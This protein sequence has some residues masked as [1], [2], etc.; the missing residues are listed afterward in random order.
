MTHCL[1]ALP[2]ARPSGE[3]L[4]VELFSAAAAMAVRQVAARTRASRS[5][6]V[7]AAI[8][9]VVAR[10]AGYR[11]LVFPL[12]SSN[13][14]DRYLASYV[15]VLA[16]TAVATVEITGRSFDELV[17]HT[18]TTVLEASRLARYDAARRHAMS[19]RIEH[20]RGLRLNLDPFF[21]SLVPESWSGLT[22]GVGVRPEEIDLAL[23]LDRAAMAPDAGQR[24][25]APVHP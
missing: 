19:Q 12:V 3:S 14:F 11:E 22:A 2:G 24:I 8:C 18:W 17:R 9:A 7:L 10:R 15:G 1:Y 6:V 23:A 16:Q 4:V 5:S 21:N 25:C 13:R 20:E